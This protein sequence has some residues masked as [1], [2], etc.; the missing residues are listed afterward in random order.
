MSFS[1]LDFG[2]CRGT[3]FEVDGIKTKSLEAICVLTYS[4]V[5]QY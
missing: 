2:G 3:E 4:E 1:L 5:E